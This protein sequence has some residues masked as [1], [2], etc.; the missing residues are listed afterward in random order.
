MKHEK[1]HEMKNNEAEK[2]SSRNSIHKIH[3][4]GGRFFIVLDSH[5]VKNLGIGEETW[6]EEKEGQ[7]GLALLI[8]NDLENGEAGPRPS[9]TSCL[10]KHH[11]L[12]HKRCLP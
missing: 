2:T 10:F 1:K 8:R 5:L 7:E 9:K 11:E 6:M 12:N 3:K 4:I